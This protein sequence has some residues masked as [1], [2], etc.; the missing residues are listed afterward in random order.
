MNTVVHY[1]IYDVA[2]AAAAVVVVNNFTET[3]E[4]VN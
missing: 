1:H 3:T 2:A 4:P